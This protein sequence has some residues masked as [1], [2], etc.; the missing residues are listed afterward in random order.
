VRG[1]VESFRSG[2]SE[3]FRPKSTAGKTPLR[4]GVSEKNNRLFFEQA[5]ITIVKKVGVFCVQPKDIKLIQ[6]Y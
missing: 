6:I 2:V 5:R 1:A 3:F 4:S